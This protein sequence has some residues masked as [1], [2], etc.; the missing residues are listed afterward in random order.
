MGIRKPYKCQICKKKRSWL[1]PIRCGGCNKKI[2]HRCATYEFCHN[3]FIHLHTADKK[4]MQSKHRKFVFIEFLLLGNIFSLIICG[5]LLM[6]H[7]LGGDFYPNLILSPL[8]IIFG[9]SVISILPMMIL[10]GALYNR[11]HPDAKEKREIW[12]RSIN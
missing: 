11:F 5:L 1:Y 7:G 10:F 12:A 4:Y 6:I 9:I 3:C 2:C 8:S